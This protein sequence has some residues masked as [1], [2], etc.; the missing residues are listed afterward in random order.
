MMK[1][2]LILL[3]KLFLFLWNINISRHAQALSFAT[4]LCLIPMTTIFLGFLIDSEL[5]KNAET[6]INKFLQINLFPKS[7]ST[8]IIENIKLFSSKALQIKTVG[9]IFLF[10]SVLFLL[11]DMESSFTEIVDNKNNKVWY[12]RI[13]SV[14]IL[15]LAPIIILCIFGIANLLSE[16]NFSGLK[17][18]LDFIIEKERNIRIIFYFLLC[19]WFMF[20]F[21]VLPHKKFSLKN[22]FLG[23]FIGTILFIIIK[24]LFEAYLKFFPNLE[25]IYGFFAIVP[26]FLLW[27]YLNWQITLY[28]LLIIYF[29]EQE[30]HKKEI[31]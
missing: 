22:T 28:S 16:L 8:N 6:Y 12:K 20:I 14:L 23:S 26:I 27:I 19:I 17:L 13:F 10:I 5:M 15:F 18:I 3:K 24:S 7:I 1:T 31:D 9:F 30:L 25:I 11:F 21:T 29:L 4:V 2:K